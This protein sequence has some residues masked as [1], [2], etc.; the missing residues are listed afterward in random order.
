MHQAPT[1][2]VHSFWPMLVTAQEA[3]HSA[4]CQALCLC[5]RLGSSLL[6]MGLHAN[7]PYGSCDLFLIMVT[8]FDGAGVSCCYE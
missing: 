1:D 6:A 5:G 7:G 3:L 4:L 2:V 8:P